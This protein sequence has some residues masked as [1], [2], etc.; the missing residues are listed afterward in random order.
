MLLIKG[1][2]FYS[3][4]NKPVNYVKAEVYDIDGNRIYKHDLLICVSGKRRDLTSAKLVHE[5]YKS[6]FDIEHFFKFAKSKLRFYK[7]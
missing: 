5:Y 7:L 2:K 3:M 1:R 6:R 4:K